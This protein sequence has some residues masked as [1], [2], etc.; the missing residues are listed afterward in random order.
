MAVL[1]AVNAKWGRGTLRLIDADDAE[2]G[3]KREMMS[4]GFTT[5]LDQLWLARWMALRALAIL[6]VGLS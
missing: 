3:M 1:D 2:L 6:L 4:K 5:S